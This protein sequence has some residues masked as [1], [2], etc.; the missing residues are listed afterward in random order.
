MSLGG[1]KFRG[2]YC[3]KG[4]LTDAQ[5]ALLMHKTKVAAFMAANTAASAGW[6]YD[7]TGSPDG[8]Y[9]CLDSVG[10]N[11]VTCFKRVI[12]A[13]TT[14][15]FC[16][17]TLTKYQ[18]T[19]STSGYVSTDKFPWCSTGKLCQFATSFVRAG[20]TQF[21]YNNA[22]NQW[23]TGQSL[24]LAT[25][26]IGPYNI[27]GW[28][29]DYLYQNVTTYSYLALSSVYFGF[30]VKGSSVVM[31][32][33]PSRSGIAVSVISEDAFSSLAVDGNNIQKNYLYCNFQSLA[34]SASDGTN[35]ESGNAY[36]ESTWYQ[37]ISRAIVSVETPNG[38]QNMQSGRSYFAISPNAQYSGNIQNYPFQSVTA[39]T[40]RG[41]EIAHTYIRG[42]VNVDLIAV[43]Y[44]PT[45]AFPTRLSTVANG[46]YLTVCSYSLPAYYQILGCVNTGSDLAGQNSQTKQ[47]V[48]YVGW[49]PSN[50]DITQASAWTE[51]TE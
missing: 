9:H 16:I 8:N 41:D 17:L 34:T 15:Y 30:A 38:E 4:S 43:N 49:D 31:F 29:T 33:G 35:M 50:P 20:V 13:D 7:M 14:H 21:S 22:A 47:Y 46:K 40:Y 6:D 36:Y 48:F 24:L 12:D 28:T 32:S 10:N 1:Y 42:E 25:G 44:P 18:T 5:W 45:G 2:Y 23:E 11:Y 27:T 37:S 19:G 26:N 3:Q 39:F 51:Y